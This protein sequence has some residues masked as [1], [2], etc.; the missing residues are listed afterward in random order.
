MLLCGIIDELI[1][2]YENKKTTMISFFFCQAT[3][4]RINSATSVLRGLIYLLVEKNPSLLSHVRARYDPAGKDLFEDINAW[5]ALTSIFTEILKDSSM[6]H[7][8]IV[9]DALDECTSGLRYL[10]DLIVQKSLAYPH[11]KWVISSRNWSEIIERLD[12]A[13]QVAPISL[14]LNE[15]S[16]SKAV[17]SFIKHKVD[18]LTKE[19]R[20]SDETRDEVYRYLSS[21][22]QG[23]FLWVALVWKNLDRTPRRLVKKKLKMF[24]PGLDALYHRMIDQVRQSEDAE[25]CKQILGTLSTVYRPITLSELRSLIEGRNDSYDG[26]DSLH[27]ILAVC[28]SFLTLREHTIMFVHQSA[29]DFLVQEI[30]NEILPR[31]IE[32]EHHAI[33][34][35]SLEVLLKALRRD[36]LDV[37]LPGF[38][39]KDISIP[40][41]HPLAAAE[42]ACI[43]WVDH[44]QAGHS[45]PGLSQDDRSHIDAFLQQ[46]YLHW[47]EALSILGNLSD[48][49]QAMQKLESLIHVSCYNHIKMSLASNIVSALNR[50]RASQK[51]Y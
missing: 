50:R 48:G 5:S 34:S 43:F 25:L 44:L 36:V 23:T 9:I 47:L 22:S 28:G 35:Q 41:P 45:A 33:F 15:A 8:Y 1:R 11:I 49:I 32:S 51:A 29:K 40:T 2:L 24:P 21:N 18:S 7:T 6:K 10:L 13:T 17:D 39:A 3:D 42:Y 31:G 37:K 16:V 19:K 46:N 26:L 20:Y 12:P 38:P 27:E 14:E 30:L 4:M